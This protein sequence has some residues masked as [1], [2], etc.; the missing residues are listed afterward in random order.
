MM[1]PTL[2]IIF[3]IVITVLTCILV[4]CLA[5]NVRDRMLLVL[6]YIAAFLSFLAGTMLL[7]HALITGQPI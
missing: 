1:G 5:C 2:Q 3:G 6:G 7:A 4:K